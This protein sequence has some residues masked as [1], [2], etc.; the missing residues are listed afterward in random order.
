MLCPVLAC[1]RPDF[2][3]RAGI[4]DRVWGNLLRLLRLLAFVNPLEP[5]FLRLPFFKGGA[6]GWLRCRSSVRKCRRTNLAVFP[7]TEKARCTVSADSPLPSSGC[8]APN[9]QA[10]WRT[11]SGASTPRTNNAHEVVL[12]RTLAQHQHAPINRRFHSYSC[13]HVSHPPVVHIDAARLHEPPRFTL[14]RRELR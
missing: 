7:G 14:R 12:P 2:S 3:R 9:V 5:L 11:D 8:L 6:S 4:A 10:V 13:L 1:R